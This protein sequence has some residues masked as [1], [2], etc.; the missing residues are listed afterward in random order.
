MKWLISILLFSSI[1]SVS[2]DWFRIQS[3]S[4]IRQRLSI[5]VATYHY[6]GPVDQSIEES[7]FPIYMTVIYDLKRTPAKIHMRI[8]SS[9]KLSNAAHLEAEEYALTYMMFLRNNRVYR[10]LF[11]PDGVDD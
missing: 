6:Q 10:M 11:I 5:F 4:P 1:Q 9:L 3:S 8:T 2:A 7:E